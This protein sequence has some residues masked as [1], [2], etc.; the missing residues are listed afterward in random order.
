MKV[1]ISGQITG[2]HYQT[3]Q[4]RFKD[5]EEF[6]TALGFDEVVNPTTGIEADIDDK[7]VLLKSMTELLE[8]DC[9][10]MLDEWDNCPTARIQH[11]IMR[12]NNKNVLYEKPQLSV[13]IDAIVEIVAGVCGV[14]VADIRSTCRRRGLV[15]ARMLC[16]YYM[17]LLGYKVIRIGLAMNRDHSMISCYMKTHNNEVK[18]NREYRELMQRCEQKIEE[19][20]IFD[21]CFTYDAEVSNL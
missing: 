20:G 13:R 10:F 14:K 11:Y 1:F 4:S 19:A 17:R 21:A 18:F 5:A 6:L 9:I 8:C 7:T 15:Y 3:M 2:L 12:I 16:V